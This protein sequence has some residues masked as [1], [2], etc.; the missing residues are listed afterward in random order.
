VTAAKRPLGRRIARGIARAIALVIALLLMALIVGYVRSGNDCGK[1]PPPTNPMQAIVYCDYGTADVLKLEPVE[2]PTPSDDQVLVKV[3]AAAVN[4]LDWHFIRGT[5][6]VMRLSAGL[7]KPKDTH[8]GV[9]FSGTVESVGKITVGTLLKA[10]RGIGFKMLVRRVP[11]LPGCL[12]LM[13]TLIF[14]ILALTS[15]LSTVLRRPI[16]RA[17]RP[18]LPGGCASAQYDLCPLVSSITAARPRR[19]MALGGRFDSSS[20]SSAACNA[21]RSGLDC[22]SIRGVRSALAARI[23]LR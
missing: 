12:L 18:G 6:Y 10:S 1:T 5:P 23:R 13:I 17:P 8:L 21:K 22:T 3:H 15:S 20:S 2:K 4:P 7:R 19:K 9:D 11:R 16:R 14:P